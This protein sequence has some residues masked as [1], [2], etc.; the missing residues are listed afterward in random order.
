[1]YCVKCGV[2]L[3]DSEKKC[4]LCQTPVYYP[5]RDENPELPYPKFVNTE[6]KISRRGLY[7]ILSILFFLGAVVPTVCD[8]SLNGRI[9]WGGYAIG[10]LILCY[11]VFLLPRW[12]YRPSPAIFV[13][14]G[15]FTAGLYLFYINMETGG[16]WFLPFALPVL[17]ALAL[18]V[19]AVVILI[20]Y[21]RAGY[22]YIF[23]GAS[24]LL[25]V[26]TMLLEMLIHKNFH[27]VHP[28][29]WSIY[30]LVIL[31]VIGL[32]LIVIA[33]VRPFRESLKKIFAI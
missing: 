11:V 28:H 30:P 21:L 16:E 33:I 7:F 12:F 10:A 8:F 15:F 18:I 24:I 6:D 31:T 1:M 13:P 29:M 32:M 17:G 27:I 5:D 23:G 25:G 2:E 19:C 20:Y 22:L 4:P 14:V 3:A 9:T 26:F